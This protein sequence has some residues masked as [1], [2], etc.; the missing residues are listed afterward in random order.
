MTSTGFIARGQTAGRR[1]STWMIVNDR[2]ATVLMLAVFAVFILS[3]MTTSSIGIAHLAQDPSAPLAVQLGSPQWIRSD[4]YNVGTPIAL[5]IMETGGTPTL[6][7]LSTPADLAHRFSSGGFFE[8]VVF[9]PGTLLAVAGFLPHQMVF[10]LYWWLPMIL[11]FIG[12]PIFIERV[13]GSRRMGWLAALL[14]ALSPAVAWWSLG[15]LNTVGYTVAGCAALSAAFTRFVS[16]RT[17]TGV[18]LAVLSGLLLT[19]IPTVY[20][21]WS[22]VIGVPM[23]LATLA[24]IVIADATWR[25]RIIPV[26][27]SGTVALIFVVGTFMEN[28][29][30]AQALLGTVY[31][32]QR[33]SGATA[34]PFE[35]LF[36]APGLGTMDSSS[37]IV[38]NASE[39]STAFTITAVW[40]FLLVIGYRRFGSW[41]S[42]IPLLILSA[43][44][45]LWLFWST[46]NLGAVGEMIPLLNLVPPYRTGQV[47]GILGAIVVSIV[48]A[49]GPARGD[50]WVALL[51]ALLSGAITLFAVSLLQTNVIPSMPTLNVLLSGCGVAAGV[52]V[53]SAYPRK[54]WP[55]VVVA[56][57][58]L[59]TVVRSQ[60]VL[61]GLADLTESDTA[62][63]LQEYGAT[64]RADG[65]LWA[66]DS[67]AFDS[68]ALANGV[69]SLS[70]FQRTGPDVEE[71]ERLD[72]D[73]EF[74]D[75]W[76][77]AGG[78]VPFIFTPGEEIKIETNGFD[79]TYVSV[80]PCDLAERFA[81]LGHIASTT[82]L[83]G[84]CLV[85]AGTA[86]WSGVEM[87]LYE[88]ARD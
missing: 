11:L 59:A 35:I 41:R 64:A 43:A 20:A 49:R 84:A 68:V 38:S 30:S 7:P 51:A 17:V 28:S 15:P 13:G 53:V 12:M 73:H 52:Y 88:V 33:R 10:S 22:I 32:G 56:V 36:G 86:Q 23:L 81:E 60:P 37:T 71:W 44:L 3:G 78:Y 57:L 31:P 47:V 58:A 54:V 50:K 34:Q 5:S 80:D 83:D 40:A 14:I 69:P 19:A 61:F 39:V 27:I 1:V 55:I 16:G 75:A 4:E 42:N 2:W 74:E 79:V 82:E 26:V 8:T 66:S 46:V 87:H 67:T 62:R 18:L 6:T 70:G 45:A 9:Y 63:L 21:P 25:S 76:N 65:T 72:P 29:A 77:R 48:L 85:E 24:A